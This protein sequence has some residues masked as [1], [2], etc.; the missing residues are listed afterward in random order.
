MGSDDAISEV[1]LVVKK[2]ATI[3]DDAYAIII[4]AMKCGTSSLFN[5]LASNPAICPCIT[6]EPE[7]FSQHQRHRRQ[8]VVAYEELWNFDPD[9]HRYALEASTGYTK[10]PQERNI[11]QKIY[12]YGIRPKFIYLVRNPFARIL[13]QYRHYLVSQPQFD[14][15]T[16]LTWSDFLDLSNYYLQLEQYRS[17]FPRKDFLV[18]DFDELKAAPQLCLN[19]V[20]A[21]L[22][23]SGVGYASNTYA[24]HN[25]G[26]SV[27]EVLVA[28]SNL[29]RMATRVF[30]RSVRHWGNRMMGRVIKERDFT[31]KERDTILNELA[32]DMRRFQADYGFDVGKW[33][34]Q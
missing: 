2:T 1:S 27:G 32:V 15:S 21:F 8:G 28:R 10:Y 26:P 34:W 31:E 23:V 13:S 14:P 7:F 9:V 25:S 30:P 20:Y 17:Y 5:Y 24:V 22:N 18:L 33:G 12:H 19:K 4:G 11:P 3:P 16:P 29:L 6:K